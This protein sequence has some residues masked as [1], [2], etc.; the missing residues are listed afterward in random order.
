MSKDTKYILV[1]LEERHSAINLGTYY[2]LDWLEPESLQL[3]STSVDNAYQNFR[4]WRT[5]IESKSPWGI[6]M[7]LRATT[8]QDKTGATI[9]SADSRPFLVESLTQTEIELLLTAL[10]DPD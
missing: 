6:Y 5:L 7:N 10:I 2:R 8:K 1:G 9:I 3:F 4:H